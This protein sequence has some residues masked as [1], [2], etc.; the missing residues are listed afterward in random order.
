VNLLSPGQSFERYTVETLVGTGGMASV[1]R[2][3]HDALGTRHALK[4]LAVAN[5]TVEKR[6]LLEGR[7]QARLRHPN[8]VSVSDIISVG[9]SYG[10]IM[11]YVDGPPMDVWLRHEK[12]S[13]EQIDA[14]AI[15]IMRG[16]AAAH[17]EG[18]VHRDL[19][20][21]NVLLAIEK[22]LMIPR[23][24]DFGL[25]KALESDLSTQVTRSGASMG[26]PAY[27]APE[28]IRAAKEV[29]PAADVWALGALLYE[30]VTGQQAFPG[31]D[32]YEVQSAV[33]EGRYP[34]LAD[35]RDDLPD[36]IRES[37][38]RALQTN[39]GERLATVEELLDVWTDGH[40]V[41]ARAD[42][43]EATDIGRA[44]E[45]GTSHKGWRSD[46]PLSD[47]MSS[48][49][50]DETYHDPSVFSP[51]LSQPPIV[52]Q[53]SQPAQPSI[54]VAPRRSPWGWVA[55]GGLLVGVLMWTWWPRPDDAPPPPAPK[56]VPVAAPLPDP[57]PAPEVAPAVAE[58]EP[59]IEPVAAPR[60]AAPRPALVPAP[61][62]AP[63][64]APEAAPV[65]TLPSVPAFA[66]VT[67]TGI[68]RALLSTEDGTFIA[69]GKV[70]PGPYQLHVFFDDT[71]ATALDRFEVDKGDEVRFVCS[72][73]LGNC[74]RR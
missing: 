65:V 61:D 70:A 49:T 20:P 36:R 26:T 58:P 19:K 50:S 9:G 57:V 27:M 21:G 29:T 60:P 8:I 33:V 46:R 17:G 22:G 4:V 62:P 16:V 71:E 45:L 47:G 44:R 14:L 63:T 34:P 11:E 73:D 43:F 38:E 42:A 64:T 10:L 13:L 32:P 18:L 15:P 6:L 7:V 72:A 35:T 68:D 23:V 51:G 2:V 53:P 54:E 28:Q 39:L 25:A 24:T 5:R 56:P 40:R 12:P 1:Y 69:P 55:F 3:R 48:G 66:V 67:V 37:I 59:H 52:P 30:L 74:R 41:Q 31:S